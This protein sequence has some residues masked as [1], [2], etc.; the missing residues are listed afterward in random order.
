MFLW[1]NKKYKYF[2]SEKSSLSGYWDD[3]DL[4]IFTYQWLNDTTFKQLDFLQSDP[5]KKKLD[6]L[7]ASIFPGPYHILSNEDVTK[8][9]ENPYRD[10]LKLLPLNKNTEVLRADNSV[11]NW[12]RL[13]ISNP[14]P[15]FHNINAQT[16]WWYLLKLL[17]GNENMDKHFIRNFGIWNFRT[18]TTMYFVCLCTPL[19]MHS[20]AISKSSNGSPCNSILSDI[21]PAQCEC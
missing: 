8:F 10:L 18:F 1:R 13:P 2:L 3:T 21:K 4:I 19:P 7:K 16:L 15:D 9:G 14:K 11:K 17:P 20:Q 6:Q 12:R 5:N